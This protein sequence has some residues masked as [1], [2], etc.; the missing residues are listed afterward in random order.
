MHVAIIQARMGS[1]RLPGKVLN[2]LGGRT[3]L[4]H[5]V[6]RAERIPA[7]DKVCC[8]IPDSAENDAL[9]DSARALGALVHRGSEHDVLSRYHGAAVTADAD[10]VVRITSDCPFLDWQVSGAVLARFLEGGVDYC[11]NLEP[12]SWPKGYDTE[13]FS[14]A[15]LERA[16]AEAREPYDRE[17]VTPFLRARDDIARAGVICSDGDFSPWRWTLDYPED[18][19]FCRAVLERAGT[20]LP[21]FEEIRAIVE[22]EPDIARVNAH[23]I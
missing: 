10:V 21:G 11:S 3:V 22:R 23:L 15:A 18:L 12:R 20:E 8:A 14:R 19:Q 7:I 2:M 13:V 6:A 1:T 17:H 5:V 9:A 16:N 4:A